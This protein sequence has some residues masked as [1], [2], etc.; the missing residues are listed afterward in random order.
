M[1]ATLS[2]VN[3]YPEKSSLVYCNPIRLIIDLVNIAWNDPS[4]S[5]GVSYACG[6][7]SISVMIEY[8][9]IVTA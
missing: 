1:Y 3:L 5:H 8:C 6:D 9:V 2:D 4:V 7:N